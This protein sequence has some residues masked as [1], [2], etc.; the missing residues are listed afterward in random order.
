L[1]PKFV[2]GGQ[3]G[4]ILEAPVFVTLGRSHD[5]TVSPTYFFGNKDPAE[6]HEPRNGVGVK[7]PKLGL[8]YRY[9]PSTKTSGRVTLGLLYDLWNQR[10]PVNPEVVVP[11]R[12]RGL[13][14]DATVQHTQDLG[15]GFR[16]RVDASYLSDGYYLRDLTADV[17]AREQQYLRST[18]TV[19]HRTENT[20]AGLDAVVRQD[21]RW[22]YSFLGR[23]YS[24]SGTRLFGPAPLQ[25][26]PRLWFAVPDTQV[27]GPVW[28]GFRAELTR[29][30]PLNSNTGDEGT[31]GVFAP[32]FPE[33]NGSQGDRQF[34]D[35]E[36]EPRTRLDLHPR[37]SASLPLG[38]VARVV[39]YLAYRQDLYFG[40]TTG[41]T[42]HRGYA[43]AGAEVSSELSRVFGKSVRHTVTPAAEIRFVPAV[44]GEGWSR[45]YDE[46]DE[47]LGKSP[48]PLLQAVVELRQRLFLNDAGKVK[49]LLSLD[50]GQGVDL[51]G[52]GRLGDAYLRVS[53]R[54]GFARLA[55]MARYDPVAGRVSYL[56]AGFGLD[57]GRGDT[58]WGHYDNLLAAGSDR[59]RRGIDALIG[60]ALPAGSS[61]RRIEQLSVGASTQFKFGLGLRY[62]ALVWPQASE[63][64]R[65]QTVGA[66]YSPACNNCW[67]VQIFRSFFADRDPTFGF[68]LSIQN[69]GTFGS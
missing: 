24:A 13:R 53:S 57:S 58:L 45:A 28:A 67:R 61:L 43:M 38:R 30:G 34:Q 59:M 14:A 63:P 11:N 65:S 44:F 68:S 25:Q 3:N 49:E 48:G 31:D 54:P 46:I 40:E 23:D 2:E 37:L 21:L 12:L 69:F 50:V 20:Y 56:S 60:P 5:V 9:A 29:M 33:A 16:N 51:L 18:A 8:E 27:K 39:P 4:T 19:N 15:R 47:A 41:Q 35:G 17:L 42:A 7:G 22:G 6:S 66:S 52:A 32:D 55:G 10:D 62:E 26:L 64:V 1:V 36:R